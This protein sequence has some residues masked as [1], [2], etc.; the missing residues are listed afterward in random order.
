MFADLLIKVLSLIREHHQQELKYNRELEPFLNVCEE[1][2]SQRNK[3][4]KRIGQLK[5]GENEHR[6]A[7][8]IDGHNESLQAAM[9]KFPDYELPL[10]VQLDIDY[11]DPQR[12]YHKELCSRMLRKFRTGRLYMNPSWKVENPMTTEEKQHEFERTVQRLINRN[13][14]LNIIILFVEQKVL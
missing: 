8:L 13:R 10:T 4:S 9:D 3:I 6:I 14:D 12:L 11:S 2:Q 1:L 5:R 7:E